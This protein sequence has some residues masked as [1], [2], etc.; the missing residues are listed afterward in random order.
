M[1]ILIVVDFKELFVLE[2]K[3]PWLRPVACDKCGG[4][5]WGHGYVWRFF[6]QAPNGCWV[7]RY[8]C[9]DCGCVITIRPVG[10][11]PRFF[12]GSENIRQALS[13]RLAQAK[14]PP[15]L[16]RQTGGYWL[17]AL[18]EQVKKI[19]GQAMEIFPNGFDELIKRS[20]VP[21]S[22]SKIGVAIPQGCCPYR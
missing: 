10:Y 16:N 3:Y 1:I 21:V 2:K 20:W 17:R 19:L 13:Y 7:K 22:R 14:W 11:W 8:Y 12:Q 9:P 5:I 4:K 18:N 6:A 15:G